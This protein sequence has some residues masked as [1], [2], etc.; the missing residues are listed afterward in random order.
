MPLCLRNNILATL[1]HRFAGQ[2]LSILINDVSAACDSV[3]GPAP[4]WG[5]Q[6]FADCHADRHG[7]GCWAVTGPRKLLD[8][9]PHRRKQPDP[10]RAF[11]RIR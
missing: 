7:V 11:G 8:C 6:R 4:G 10:I 1:P 9:S 3:W 2:R 5:V